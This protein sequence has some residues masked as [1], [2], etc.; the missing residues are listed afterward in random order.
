LMTSG[1]ISHGQKAMGSC[2]PRSKTVIKLSSW[3]DKHAC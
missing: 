2:L 3:H 1:T